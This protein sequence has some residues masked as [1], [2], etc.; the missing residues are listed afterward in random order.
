MTQYIHQEL[1]EELR[2][3]SGYYSII[4]EGRLKYHQREVLYVVGVAG[5]DNSCCGAAGCRFINI[6][7]YILSWKKKGGDSSPGISEVDPITDE[8]EQREIKEILDI[9]YPYSQI[10]F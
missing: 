9:G 4:E 10:Y 5:I 6:P 2:T 3:V 1:D 8:E 7:G